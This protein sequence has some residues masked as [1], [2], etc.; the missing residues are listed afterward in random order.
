MAK[1]RIGL[2]ETGC[3]IRYCPCQHESGRDGVAFSVIVWNVQRRAGWWDYFEQLLR[4]DIALLQ[5]VD[6]APMPMR[7]GG[8]RKKIDGS[9]RPPW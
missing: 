2:I 1:R 7:L 4:S 3:G 6:T 8:V 5:E 9:R